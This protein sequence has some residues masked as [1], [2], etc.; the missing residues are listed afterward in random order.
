M[1][2][3]ERCVGCGVAVPVIEG[4]VHRY[5]TSAPACWQRY[6][7]LLALLYSRPGLGQAVI[8]AADTY[9]VQ[10]P[11]SPNPQA[12]QSVDIHLL[13]LYAYLV[14]GRPVRN[15][16]KTFGARA[17]H[18]IAAPE[19]RERYWLDPPAFTG[20]LTVFDMPLSGPDAAIQ[21]RASAWAESAWDAWRAHHA[22]VAAWYDDYALPQARR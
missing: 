9:A 7:E 13:N 19:E 22:Q 15:P 14:R 4:P 5:M 20:A 12:I 8:I 11:G 10:H 18:A 3:I 6:G 1:T 17:F 21:D 2:G 16:Q